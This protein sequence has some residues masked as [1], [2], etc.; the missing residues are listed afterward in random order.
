MSST[1][2]PPALPQSA[3]PATPANPWLGLVSYTEQDRNLFFGR[4]GEKAELLRLIERE[5]LTVLFGRS[6][7]GKTSLLRAGI[8]PTLRE[9]GYF[10]VVLRLDYSAQRLNPI[11]Q[12]KALFREAAQA[13]GIDV[14]N[15][16]ADQ[17]VTLWEYFHMIECWG[18]RNDRLTPILVFDQF[19]E[20]FTI[21][22]NVDA[23]TGFLDQLADLVEN[24]IPSGLQN[25][26][27]QT[28]ERLS[29]NP[30]TRNY[31]I[32]LSLRED[33]VSRLDSLRP[34]MPAIMRNRLGLNPL[35]GERALG[36]ILH[37]GAQWVAEGV[38][39]DIVAAVA[40]R[41]QRG[42]LVSTAFT[43]Q[44]EIEPA[45][46]S[47]MCHELFR[48]MLATGRN[49]ITHDLVE[50]EQGGILEG[51]Y[52]R[53]FEGLDPKL[54]TFVE[55]K[56]VSEAGF[57]MPV[58]LVEAIAEDV[59]DKDLNILVDRRLLRFDD[60]LGTRYVELSHDLLTQVV[61][62]SRNERRAA[63]LRQ[64]LIRSRIR[65]A[66][67]AS[68]ATVLLGILVFGYFAYFYKFDIYSS[69]Y[70]KRFGVA[71]PIDT[72]SRKTGGHRSFSF[73]FVRRGFKPFNGTIL[74]MEA[75][76]STGHLT[77]RHNVGTYLSSSENQLPEQSK[78]CQW[79][80]VYDPNGQVTYEIARDRFDRMVFGFVYSPHNQGSGQSG[81]RNAMF[82]GPD[83]YPQPQSKSSAEYVEIIYDQRGYESM[84]R[85]TDR[86][87][88][89]A[90]G[91]DGAF[92]RSFEYND[93]G[94]LTRLTSLDKNSMPM[95][96]NAWNATIVLEYDAHG[97]NVGDTA[98]D[99]H[100]HV[101]LLKNGY[102]KA[103]YRYD[104]WENL[105]EIR[106]LDPLDR[107]ALNAS[108][109]AYGTRFKYDDHG[110]TTEYAFYNG[111]WEPLDNSVRGFHA[112]RTEY[113]K[114]NRPLSY[115]YF[116]K[117]LQPMQFPTGWHQVRYSY[118][119]KGFHEQ[120]LY[121]DKDGQPLKGTYQKVL[122][123][124]NE[125]GQ[126]LE[127]KYYNADSS[128]TSGP[129]GH[130]H[131]RRGRYDIHG[132]LVEYTYYGVDGAPATDAADGAHRVVLEY[133]RFRNVITLT[134]YG[135]DDKAPINARAGYHRRKSEYDDFGHPIN[136]RYF[137]AQEHPVAPDGVQQI[138]GKYD[139]RG[140]PLEMRN[141][142]INGQAVGDKDGIFRIAFEYNDKRQLTRRECFDVFN[143]DAA[144]KDGIHLEVQE[145][146]DIGRRV[147]LKQIRKDG[148]GFLNRIP[149]AASVRYNLD[150]QGNE[151]EEDFYDA[152]D[153]PVIGPFGCAKETITRSDDGKI[154]YS[155]FGPDGR[156]LFNRLLGYARGQQI[157]RN[158][159]LVRETYY[160]A[161][162]SLT[163]G[164]SGYAIHTIEAD[165]TAQGEVE[166]FLDQN[167]RPTFG[168]GGYSKRQSRSVGGKTENTYFDANDRAMDHPEN[169]VR[170]LYISQIS[171]MN[172]VAA[173]IGILPGDIL[174]RLGG[175][176][177][178]KALERAQADAK[179]RDEIG[180]LLTASF[181]AA[182]EITKKMPSHIEV[183]RDG[184]VVTL[185][186]PRLPDGL[187]GMTF[188][189]RVMPQTVYE[190]TFSRF[191]ISPRTH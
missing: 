9:T 65:T 2:Q 187:F 27:A 83:G 74:S 78:E 58:P 162:G 157:F 56:L 128:P 143:R 106:Y 19:E 7:L 49:A 118:N 155:Y 167:Q 18:P 179:K 55:E 66:L 124:N 36:V 105:I 163:N 190:Q 186:C 12:V 173:R 87:G 43:P 33:F 129:D 92:G 96:D 20:V 140:L 17:E 97:N 3:S 47:V 181:M 109:G 115:S 134:Y 127:E 35:D 158:D 29:I 102:S 45:Y 165:S 13:N 89:P 150:S 8:I 15:A 39:R 37:A 99:R 77:T 144:C 82:V 160:S 120:E 154:D 25:R 152:K 122:R 133:D 108:T 57:R 168:P 123:R 103:K 191:T 142:G 54:R 110:N 153:R 30:G 53:S 184:R 139:D 60:R 131:I 10:P 94:Q 51:L 113:D 119:D 95:N 75:I 138:I 149:G 145:Y 182:R 100:G 90:P 116:D 73:K 175:W 107:P 14:E 40:G 52:E 76:D 189:P 44:A 64:D 1:H 136:E 137:D 69:G 125:F 50:Q 84:Q 68:M 62:K 98:L 141:I 176:S 174:W 46:L 135:A 34:L 177:L 48:R 156:S 72:I 159:K 164:P 111:S 101:T 6:G 132:N 93:R 28:N 183:V 104:D 71:E 5:S 161:D 121:Y 185:A 112:V 91:P 61:Q 171:S 4:E 70:R 67:A 146:D 81:M 79:Q 31:K 151:V 130:Y 21:G 32:V 178:P 114:K 42:S 22:R 172:A 41:G 59:P 24:R 16:P 126:A 147:L 180:D 166:K 86:A 38:A 169:G 148:T 11:E 88:N 170:V 63:K 80:F 188:A 85:F 23:T 26:I 117:S